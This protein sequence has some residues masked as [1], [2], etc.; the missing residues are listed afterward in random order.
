MLYSTIV[1][2]VLPHLHCLPVS[3]A[4]SPPDSNHSP[5]TLPKCV[6][7]LLSSTTSSTIYKKKRIVSIII[8]FTASITILA[9]LCPLPA[10]INKLSHSLQHCCESVFRNSMAIY[11]DTYKI[12]RNED[13][14]SIRCNFHK[15]LS[16]VYIY[17]TYMFP[18]IFEHIVHTYIH[19]FTE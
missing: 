18:Y 10:S 7:Q 4:S 3:P 17:C 1:S 5:F 16:F 15:V 8:A 11:I 12:F 6:L 19:L 13:I 9:C 2:P 14:H